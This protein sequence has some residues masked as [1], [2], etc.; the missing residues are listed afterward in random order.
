MSPITTLAAVLFLSSLSTTGAAAELR[1]NRFH[2]GTMISSPQIYNHCEVGDAPCEQ[3]NQRVYRRVQ[4]AIKAGQNTHYGMLLDVVIADE[5]RPLSVEKVEG[6]N[7]DILTFSPR[8]NENVSVNCG[9]KP[10]PFMLAGSINLTTAML[11]RKSSY[12]TIYLGHNRIYKLSLPDSVVQAVVEAAVAEL[13]TQAPATVESGPRLNNAEVVSV[14]KK[15]EAVNTRKDKFET[16]AEFEARAATW[17]VPFLVRLA[18]T[19]PEGLKESFSYDADTQIATFSFVLDAPFSSRS[20]GE[21]GYRSERMQAALLDEKRSTIGKYVGRT[22]LGAK[23]SVTEVFTERRGVMFVNAD[24]TSLSLKL[25]RDRAR[26]FLKNGYLVLY[27]K[28]LPNLS[29]P[30]WLEAQHL[31]ATL[32]LPIELTVGHSWLPLSLEQVELV[33]K[34]GNVIISHEFSE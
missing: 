14:I 12:V 2:E 24:K 10:C 13:D 27:A 34:G 6:S 15:F 1:I 4:S 28:S 33:D 11:A 23:V 20:A 18:I 26:E 5:A 31:N 22:P 21:R 3:A 25:N 9:V 16:T 29:E 17:K 30:L 7:G 19:L 8:K 32:K